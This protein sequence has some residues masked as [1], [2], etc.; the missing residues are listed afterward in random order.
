MRFEAPH[1]VVSKAF[2]FFIGLISVAI[3]LVVFLFVRTVWGISN[4]GYELTDSDIV[5]TFGPNRTRIPRAEVAG[6]YV[7][8]Q[9]TRGWRYFGTN[10][11]GLK[12]GRWTFA[13]TGDITLYA[14]SVRPLTVIETE[15]RKWGISPEDP[16]AF[17]TAFQAGS[18]G[19]FAPVAVSDHS[20]LIGLSSLLLLAAIVSLGVL[21]YVIRLA[22]TISY[23]LGPT[24]VLIRGG[25]KPVEIPYERITEVRIDEPAGLPFRTYGVSMPKLYW[26]SF[27]WK[28]VGPNLTLHATRLRPLVVIS[29]G[30]RTYGLSPSDPDTF[31]QELKRRLSGA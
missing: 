7:V 12:E 21:I 16:E 17:V 15:Q 28:P 4:L 22:K 3:L 31:V 30:K 23:E 26:G 10:A 29:T 2:W 13:E 8:E 11:P 18:T 5:I 25:L 24:A 19:H 20:S 27:S 9:P 1:A 6:V 14:T